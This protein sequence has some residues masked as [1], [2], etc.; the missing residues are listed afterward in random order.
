MPPVPG[1]PF[2]LEGFVRIDGGPCPSQLD[3]AE[4]Q[5]VFPLDRPRVLTLCGRHFM[6][7]LGASEALE[8]ALAE[9]GRERWQTGN[10]ALWL[11][12]LAPAFG[13]D[14]ASLPPAAHVAAACDGVGTTALAAAHDIVADPRPA[15]AAFFHRRWRAPAG[16]C[17]ICGEAAPGERRF[18]T[19][20]G[21]D[22]GDAIHAGCMARMGIIGPL[23]GELAAAQAGVVAA[24]EPVAAPLGED[25]SLWDEDVG[26]GEEAASSPV[27]GAS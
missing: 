16:G 26:V 7:G 1:D 2:E 22:D 10:A 14:P 15:R 11:A 20:W 3:P 12:A 23:F 17:L 18:R 8:Q 6:A 5:A 21:Q 9:I 27:E 25:V 24:R 4:W 13:A 19:S